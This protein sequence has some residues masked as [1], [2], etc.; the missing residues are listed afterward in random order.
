MFNKVLV[1]NR[2]AV[3]ARILRG[4]GGLTTAPIQADQG[5]RDTPEF[6]ARLSATG[7]VARGL[8]VRQISLENPR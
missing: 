4:V 7:E 3:A 2:G 5:L 1:A 8:W 6:S